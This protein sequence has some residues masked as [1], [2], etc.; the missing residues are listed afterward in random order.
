MVPTALR[1]LDSSCNWE[2]HFCAGHKCRAYQGPEPKAAQQPRSGALQQLKLETGLH[3][4]LRCQQVA[5]LQSLGLSTSQ[6]KRLVAAFPAAILELPLT[7]LEAAIAALQSCGFADNSLRR[8]LCKAPAVLGRSP[9]EIQAVRRCDD[10]TRIGA[11]QIHFTSCCGPCA[12][13]STNWQH[14]DAQHALN[15]HPHPRD[16]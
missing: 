7:H 9:D 1:V 12:T 11:R 5:Y 2:N 10:D 14:S 4:L 16:S 13:S 3:W 6:V 8:L 15:G